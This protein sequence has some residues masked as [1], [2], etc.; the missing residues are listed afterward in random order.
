M[1]ASAAIA[2]LCVWTHADNG[3]AAS[4]FIVVREASA[5]AWIDS[6]SEEL[7]MYSLGH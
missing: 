2:C 5:G 6:L 7:T 3:F 4:T 1:N